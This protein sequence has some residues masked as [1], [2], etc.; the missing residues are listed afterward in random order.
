MAL[1]IIFFVALTFN[2]KKL[3]RI[4]REHKTTFEW[5]IVDIK[6]ISY[7]IYMHK[8]LI[9]DNYKPSVKHQRRLNPT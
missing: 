4:L 8:I 1:P 2:K 9:E 5:S 7:S 6:G 3:L